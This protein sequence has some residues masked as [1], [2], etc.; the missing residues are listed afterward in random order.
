MTTRSRSSRCLLMNFF[1][2][3]NLVE[4]CRRGAVHA[5]CPT[6]HVKEEL[7][8]SKSRAIYAAKWAQI[9]ARLLSERLWMVNSTLKVDLQHFMAHSLQVREATDW[10]Y[11]ALVLSRRCAYANC[12]LPRHQTS[13]GHIEFLHSFSFYLHCRVPTYGMRC[14]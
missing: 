2:L 9:I 13:W 1:P 4:P 3:A 5:L 10:C 8:K 6:R 7:G 11:L 14:A 12:R